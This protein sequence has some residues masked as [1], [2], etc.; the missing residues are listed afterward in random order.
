MTLATNPD[1]AILKSFSIRDNTCFVLMHHDDDIYSTGVLVDTPKQ[2]GY[3]GGWRLFG[4]IKYKS[5]RAAVIA[6]NKLT[7]SIPVKVY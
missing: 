2:D 1:F 6:Y 5:K 7:K 3:S 4:E